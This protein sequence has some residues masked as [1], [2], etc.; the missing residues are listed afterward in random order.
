MTESTPNAVKL[1]DE[2]GMLVLKA[3]LSPNGRIIRIILPELQG[4]GQIK[5][6][7]DGPVKYLQFYR[8]PKTK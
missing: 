4:Y 2:A 8:D 3:Y 6:F 1:H 7:V 5:H